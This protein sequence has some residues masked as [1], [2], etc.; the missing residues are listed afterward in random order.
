[1]T[2][3][4]WI[5]LLKLFLW[6]EYFAIRTIYSFDTDYFSARSIDKLM[7]DP[8]SNSINATGLVFGA[9]Q[10]RHLILIYEF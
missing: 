2:L 1:M 10:G 4:T 5:H 7:Q 6:G 8:R 3:N 9:Q